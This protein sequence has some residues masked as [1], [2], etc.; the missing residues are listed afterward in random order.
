M[1]DKLLEE[2]RKKYK[3]YFEPLKI[4]DKELYF[5]QIEDMVEQ[6]E[7]CLNSGQGISSLYWAKI[8][9]GSVLLAYMLSK[10]PLNTV[11]ETKTCLEI[12]AGIGVAGLFAASFGYQVTLSDIHGDALLFA[13]INALKNNLDVKVKRVD[14]PKDKLD[15]RYDL[16]LASEVFY[17][18]YLME[19][20]LLFFKE[21]LKSDGTVYMVQNLRTNPKEFQKIAQRDFLV[22]SKF[23]RLRSETE[24]HTLL[25]YKLRPRL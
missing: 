17:N 20:L 10:Q 23:L 12:G 4:G 19:P 21:H 15:E 11:L 6:I 1:L 16:I 8:W 14:F 5:L 22:E 7:R 13:Q 9:E 24:T 2:A 18:K 25:F 3:I